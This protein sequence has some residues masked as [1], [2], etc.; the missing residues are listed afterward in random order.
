[1]HLLDD[2]SPRLEPSPTDEI[3]AVRDRRER[4][5]KNL[6]ENLPP[7]GRGNHDGQ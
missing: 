2:S 6:P 4:P 1:M 5:L 7:S 3:R